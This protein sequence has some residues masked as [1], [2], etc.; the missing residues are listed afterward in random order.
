[1]TDLVEGS[2]LAA[3][4]RYVDACEY[5]RGFSAQSVIEKCLL[6]GEETGE[7]FRAVRKASGLKTDPAS[8]A[9]DVGEELA[10]MLNPQH[11]RTAR[12]G[13]CSTRVAY[14]GEAEAVLDDGLVDYRRVLCA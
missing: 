14:F 12:C 13:S 6:L 4:Q 1:M 11:S 9:V 7:L 2:S 8:K 5:E 10:D 3:L